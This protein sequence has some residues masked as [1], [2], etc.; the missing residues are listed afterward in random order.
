MSAAS[1]LGLDF[2]DRLRSS[3][4][5]G[6]TD[7]IGIE[8]TS[9]LKL[10][11]LLICLAVTLP[12]QGASIQSDALAP[13]T[14][15]E[16]G[17]SKYAEATEQGTIASKSQVGADDAVRNQTRRILQK[18]YEQLL[19]AQNANGNLEVLQRVSLTGP[20]SRLRT[21]L[22]A[23]IRYERSLDKVLKHKHPDLIQA[24]AELRAINAQF[25]SRL[26]PLVRRAK[27][28]W[29]AAD[30]AVVTKSQRPSMEVARRY[31]ALTNEADSL[32]S[33]EQETD[34][35]D[36]SKPV[37]ATVSEPDLQPPQ[38]STPLQK[39]TLDP[40]SMSQSASPSHP[41]LILSLGFLA[42]LCLGILSARVKDTWERHVTSSARLALVSGY[43]VLPAIPR[44]DAVGLPAAWYHSK[45]KHIE[46]GPYSD[47]LS[48]LAGTFDDDGANYRLAISRLL[49]RIKSHRRPGRPHC[50]LFASPRTGVGNSALTLSLS[51]A[52][53]LEGARVLVVDATS[54]SPSIAQAFG[55][56]LKSDGVIA[57]DSKEQLSQI[58]FVDGSSGLS[59]LPIS[60]LGLDALTD[61]Q[62]RRLV[63]GLNKVSQ[64][65]DLIFVDCGGLLGGEWSSFLLDY[66]DQI[67]F[68]ARA[69][70]TTVADVLQTMALIEP[71]RSRISG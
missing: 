22:I 48:A 6:V 59:I 4:Q 66:A 63:A 12:V 68:V 47:L 42:G 56:S 70:V 5:P 28:E 69:R 71:S 20:V 49:T 45:N 57:L 67:V 15:H 14:Q 8:L 65:Y 51:Y 44:H 9:A 52:A 19:A 36:L 18:T 55:A 25:V 35:P 39:E 26:R 7:R 24:R 61:A 27:A 16:H 2:D 29:L 50:I 13:R 34:I 58:I 1:I 3:S 38:P 30:A 43:P 31:Q 37:A 21:K 17:H 60:L 32:V 41:I 46:A 53:A 23:A 40:I 54:K 11:C 62:R 10:L 33:S 64:N